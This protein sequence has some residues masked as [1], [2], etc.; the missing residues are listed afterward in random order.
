MN[1][2]FMS[3]KGSK[4][5]VLCLLNILG[6]SFTED[7]NGYAR[8]EK[9]VSRDLYNALTQFFTMFPKLQSR[10]FYVAGQSYGGNEVVHINN[11]L[12]FSKLFQNKI[13]N[14]LH[15][16][17]SFCKTGKERNLQEDINIKVGN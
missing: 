15:A 3:I 7:E 9:D 8:N 10:D 13:V 17:S 12:E 16:I 6:F 14:D 4:G 5:N 2:S 1:P 11:F